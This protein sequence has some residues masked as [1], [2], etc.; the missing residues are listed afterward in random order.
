MSCRKVKKSLVRYVDGDLGGKRGDEVR[1]HLD[2]CPECRALAE[3]LEVSSAALSSLRPVELSDAASRRILGAVQAAGAPRKML[4]PGW[5]RSPTALAVAGAGAALILACVVVVGVFVAGPGPG[6]ETTAPL[7]TEEK[8]S[9]SGATD[10]FDAEPEGIDVQRMKT[11]EFH[12][13]PPTPV[14]K[15]TSTNYTEQSLREMFENL[16]V[17]KTFGQRYTMGNA[18]S[19]APSFIDNVTTQYEDLGQD[20]AMLESMISFIT[21]GEPALLACYVEKA[22]FRGLDVTI[23]GLCAPPRSG[24]TTRLTR[25]EAWVMDPV[26]FEADPN[27]SIVH[28]LEMK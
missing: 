14:V 4:L 1:E 11:A 27:T 17:K 23:I 12:G 25:A 2:G 13:P 7:V 28:F 9:D 20:P 19:L 18:I 22:L 21:T 5:L 26:R 15:A 8:A 3:K 16:E 10:L 24:S 6:T